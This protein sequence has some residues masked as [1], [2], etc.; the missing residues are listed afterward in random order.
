MI[1]WVIFYLVCVGEL[2]FGCSRRQIDELG[3]LELAGKHKVKCCP[4]SCPCL[5]SCCIVSVTAVGACANL[6][7]A[8]SLTVFSQAMCSSRGPVGASAT[9]FNLCEC[10]E[11][12]GVIKL[13]LLFLKRQIWSL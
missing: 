3:D 9:F 1:F 8:L 10:V 5:S 11:L 2:G 12:L 4:I 6:S 7:T 13:L